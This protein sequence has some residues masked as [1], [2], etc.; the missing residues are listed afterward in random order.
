MSF[1][2]FGRSRIAPRIAGLSLLFVTALAALAPAQP[3]PVVLEMGGGGDTRWEAIQL[4]L[5]DLHVARQIPL[6][7]GVIPCRQDGGSTSCPDD[8]SLHPTFRRWTHDHPRIIEVGQHGRNNTESLATLSL[9]EQQALIES[10]LD[11]LLRWQLANGEPL[12]FIPALSSSNADTMTALENLGFQT[13]APITGSCPRTS[14]MDRFCGTVSLCRPSASGA[15]VYGPACVVKTFSELAAEIDAR[16]AQ[17][18]VAVAFFPQDLSV[19]TSNQAMSASKRTAYQA[20]LDGFAGAEA[21]GRYDLRTFDTHYRVTRGLPLPDPQPTPTPLPTAA[22]PPPENLPVVFTEDDPEDGTWESATIAVHDLFIEERVPLVQQTVP[23]GAPSPTDGSACVNTG[24]HRLYGDWVRANPDLFE[25]SQ[26]GVTHD[27]VLD[28]LPRAE[29]RARIERGLQEMMTWGLPERPWTFA[30]P[31]SSLDADTVSVLEELG[32]HTYEKNAGSCP[33]SAIM[34]GWCDSVPMCRIVDGF[35]PSGPSCVFRSPAELIDEVNRRALTLDR[36]FLNFH[37]QDVYLGDLRTIDPAKIDALRAILRAFRDAEVAGYYD[38]MTM[39]T[40]WKRENG[41]PTPGPGP[42]PTPT[43]PP[44]SEGDAI[45]RETLAS[46]WTNA[47]WSASV[48]LA[49]GA[50]AFGGTRSIRVQQVGWGALSVRS[51]AFAMAE[52]LDPAS[53][54]GV[55]FQVWSETSNVRIS[56]RLE[57]GSQTFPEVSF[58]AVPTGR[59]TRVFL[60]IGELAPSGLPFDRISI[61][62]RN[63]TDATYF[64][65]D[66]IL[67]RS[68]SAPPPTPTPVATS[69]PQPTPTPP[70]PTP[71]PTQTPLAAGTHV[72]FAESLAAPWRNASWSATV[73][74]ASTVRAFNGSASIRVVQ[75]GWGALSVRRGTFSAPQPFAASSHASVDFAVWNES[76][77]FRL[78]VRLENVAGQAFP[79]IVFGDVP[80]GQWTRVSVPISALNPNGFAYDRVDVRNFNGTNVTYSVDDLVLS[81]P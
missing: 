12:F 6:S 1:P 73:D 62:N 25:V 16:A 74:F 36:V 79:E 61:R 29:Q 81:A 69:T 20:L 43:P 5:G 7:I 27:E 32:F 55:E 78:S 48:D 66:L 38:L 44:P 35:R 2:A 41:L 46:P 17:D 22:V 75:T 72:I 9:A 37:V 19:S 15:R 13:F 33:P 8:G 31:F 47:S 49:S 59:W 51:G 45:Y 21:S 80:V 4:E 23:C 3:L 64:V 14:P 11:A 53:Y 76:P 40:Y 26:H 42:L 57:A 77:N 28:T 63:G 18:A 30:P 56:V 71:L 68:S 67:V 10:G 65:D 70:A 52:P 34:T 54:D 39:E 50:R 60:P 58:G 24:L